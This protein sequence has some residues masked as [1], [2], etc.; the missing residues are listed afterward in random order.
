[1]TA[2]NELVT[3][4]RCPACGATC[5]LRF[6]MH[7]WASYDGDAS[8]RFAVRTYR[9]GEP[10]AWWP[11]SDPRHG[12]WADGADAVLLASGDVAEQ[13][14]GVCGCCRAEL[15]ATVVFRD[16]RPALITDVTLDLGQPPSASGLT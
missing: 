5:E 2:Y 1:M 4:E 6:Q 10:L 7:A 3:L 12:R 8:G 13:C 11:L 16:L 14:Y 15:L 9:L